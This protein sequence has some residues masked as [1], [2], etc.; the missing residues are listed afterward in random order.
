MARCCHRCRASWPWRER[1]AR[2]A[3]ITAVQLEQLSIVNTLLI[4]NQG[5][6]ESW[7]D[8]AEA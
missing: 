3:A 1:R 6:A 5:N 7:I 8:V 2:E 4:N